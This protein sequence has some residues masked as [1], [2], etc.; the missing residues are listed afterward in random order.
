MSIAELS[1]PEPG[2][3]IAGK[4]RVSRVLASGGMGVVV[5]AEHASLGQSVAIKFL[6]PEARQQPELV[7]RFLREARAAARLH[8]DHVVRVFDMGTDDAGVP[9][10][11]MELLSGNDLGDELHHRG[12]LPVAEAVGYVVE[13][14]EAIVEAHAAGIVHRDLKPS[15]LFLVAKPD[16]GRRLKVLDFG[17]SKVATT[18]APDAALTTTKSMLGSPGYM[19][20]EQVRSTRS[21]DP[22]TDIWALGV[23]LYEALSGE[24]AFLG[25]TLGDIFAKIREEDLPPIRDR[26][27]DVP[28]GLA[29]VLAQALQRD[30][31]KRI[32][33]AATMRRQLLPFTAEGAARASL[34]SLEESVV[35][36]RTIASSAPTLALDDG[37]LDDG[38]DARVDAAPRVGSETLAT[39]TGNHTTKRKGALVAGVALAAGVLALGAWLALRP[40]RGAPSVEAGRT[41]ASPGDPPP[42][43]GVDTGAH[44]GAGAL[45]PPA[46]SAAVPVVSPAEASGNAAPS[47][48]SAAADAGAPS[49][50]RTLPR[51]PAATPGPP[52]AR[53]TPPAPTA[54]KKEDLGI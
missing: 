33:D 18:A 7:E 43:A 31:G 38:P 39:W 47:A 24:P 10:M 44:A 26:R 17:I 19:S 54:R 23:I 2:S 40:A 11:V 12:R 28:E 46:P 14:L 34:A 51:A 20:P 41:S 32:P 1:A 42:A 16:G 27:P 9:F 37:A 49:S 50:P 52:A 22:R 3:L 29:D 30:R 15:N 48:P 5:E 35:R 21:V 53:P 8:S 4:Y 25:E 6:L 36:A 13:A 45:V